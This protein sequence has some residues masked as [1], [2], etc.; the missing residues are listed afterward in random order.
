[1][2]CMSFVI[3]TVD[4]YT[5]RMLMF[6]SE[7]SHFSSDSDFEDKA[8]KVA[9][10]PVSSDDDI[11]DIQQPSVEDTNNEVWQTTTFTCTLDTRNTRMSGYT[12]VNLSY[13]TRLVMYLVYSY[14]LSTCRP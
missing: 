5:Y 14:Q 12:L 9:L 7:E 3:L 11:E 1:M 10:V 6:S 2:H 13:I 8:P 4:L